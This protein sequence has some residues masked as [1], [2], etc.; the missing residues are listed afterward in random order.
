MAASSPKGAFS[1]DV[2]SDRRCIGLRKCDFFLG[3]REVLDGGARWQE[4]GGTM[5]FA[6]LAFHGT[7]FFA[8]GRL[9]PRK[10]EGE[11]LAFLKNK[12]ATPVCRHCGRDFLPI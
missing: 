11:G 6:P 9:E 4:T 12:S 1:R 2:P 10:M 8:D 3:G 7:G 5:P